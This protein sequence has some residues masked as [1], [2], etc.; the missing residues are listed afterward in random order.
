MD[1][2]PT[3]YNGHRFRSRLEARFAVFFEA[4]KVPYEYEPEG[5]RL[6]DG[7]CYLPDFRVKCFGTRGNSEGRPFDLYIEVKGVMTPE[8]E[9]KIRH[10]CGMAPGQDR[11]RLDDYPPLLIVDRIPPHGVIMDS[12]I[13]GCYEPMLGSH[14]CPFNYETI[15]G[16]CFGAYPAAT[17]DGRFYLM[18][19]DGSYSCTDAEA[20]HIREAYDKAR[21]A[22]FEHGVK[23]W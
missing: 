8:D 5:F 22:Q 20:K 13:F 9:H 12:Y 16:D 23:G 10:F 1:V 15:D 3:Y 11:R 4:L 14:L 7:T 21:Q 6:D 19:D 18:G 2:I 17:L